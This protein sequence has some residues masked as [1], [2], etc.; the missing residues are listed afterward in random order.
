M[1]QEIYHCF[2]TW[3]FFYFLSFLT[4]RFTASH[5]GLS[6]TQL[7]EVWK[8]VSRAPL[9]SQSV[10]TG[11]DLIRTTTSPR[12]S[13]TAWS[14]RKTL[15]RGSCTFQAVMGVFRVCSETRMEE[16][17]KR[18]RKSHHPKHTCNEGDTLEELTGIFKG[19]L[20]G[21]SSQTIPF[22]ITQRFLQCITSLLEPYL[23]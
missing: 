12:K 19:L 11:K 16:E 20:I 4:R 17:L 18:E 14:P 2:R 13:P 1:N 3:I 6:L 8:S 21:H 15:E 9:R 10:N 22:D 23:N 7:A 5:W